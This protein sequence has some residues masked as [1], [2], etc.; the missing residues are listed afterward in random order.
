MQSKSK[1]K[2]LKRPSIRV[3]RIE[4]MVGLTKNFKLF[5]NSVGVPM[6]DSPETSATGMPIALDSCQFRAVIS[7]ITYSYEGFVP[8][9]IEIT[10]LQ[11]Y[12]KGVAYSRPIAICE[13]DVLLN[14]CPLLEVVHLFLNSQTSKSFD[15]NASTLLAELKK[16]ANQNAI[17]MGCKGMPKGAN[18]LSRYMSDQKE[19][20]RRLHIELNVGRKDGKQRYIKLRLKDDDHRSSPSKEP[21]SPNVCP[22]KTLQADVDCDDAIFDQ[23]NRKEARL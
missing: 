13:S 16:I 6:V 5:T 11:T 8:R 22:P 2:S 12:L 18:T 1:R 20:L 23:I 19:S 21:S 14:D 15:G 4:A 17:D 9:E 3:Q 10:Q 7:R